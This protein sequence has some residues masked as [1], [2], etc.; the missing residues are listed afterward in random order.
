MSALSGEGAIV[1]NEE[2]APSMVDETRLRELPTTPRGQRTRERL[3]KAA[4]VVFERDGFIDSRLTDITH[5]ATCSIGSFYNYFSSKEEILAAVLLEAQDSMLHPGQASSA[6]D[7]E[8]SPVAGLEAA[9]R[10]YL[11]AYQ[12]NARLML[13]MDQVAGIDPQF[14]ELRLQRGQAFIERNAR[15]IAELQRDGLVDPDLSPYLTSRALSAMVSRLAFNT[16]SLGVSADFEELVFTITRL[17]ANA[18]GLTCAERG[19]T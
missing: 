12:R 17:W 10:A 3:V 16:F 7:H 19:H 1:R 4:R 5:E 8:S 2:L 6:I 11:E 9:N 14:R 18:L 15:Q 13:L